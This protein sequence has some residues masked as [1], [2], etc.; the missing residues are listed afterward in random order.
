MVK[1]ADKVTVGDEMPVMFGTAT[2]RVLVTMRD[3]AG[4]VV[5]LYRGGTREILAPTDL[6]EIR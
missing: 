6:V 1:T 2:V 4:N 5:I 3:I